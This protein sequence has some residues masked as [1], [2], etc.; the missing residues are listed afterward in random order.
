MDAPLDTAEMQQWLTRTLDGTPVGVRRL[1]APPLRIAV[2]EIDEADPVAA[3]NP[4]GFTYYP[5]MLE[6]DPLPPAD[7]PVYVAA[8]SSLLQ[9][10]WS[11]GWRAVAACDFEDELPYSGGFRDGRLTVPVA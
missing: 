10:L 7:R 4:D 8:V 3:A 9:T 2:V 6:V 11:A 1:D 5:I